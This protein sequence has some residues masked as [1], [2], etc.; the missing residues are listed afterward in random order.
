MNYLDD[1]MQ[2]VGDAIGGVVGHASTP[3]R[4]Q[5]ITISR[6]REQ[7]KQ[8]WRD[9]ASLSAL[10]DGTAE[11]RGTD[12]PGEFVWTPGDASD[13]GAAWRTVLHQDGD[14]FR[15]TTARRDDSGPR[16]GFSLDFRDAPHDLGTEVT[17]RPETP[18]P[19]F[20]SSLATF[21]VL[22]R[23]RALL[24]TGEVPTLRGNPSARRNSQ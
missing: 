4:P 3:D 13:G 22:Y 9:P 5:T 8:F 24:Q 10:L 19:E 15:F 17:M 23:A 11:V 1:I 12:A 2:K 16:P 6:P 20:L 7:V 18:L 14:T 21:A